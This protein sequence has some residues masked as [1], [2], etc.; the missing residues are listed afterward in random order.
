ME[1]EHCAMAG[2]NVPF[3]TGNYGITTTPQDEFNIA[4]GRMQ[5]SDINM[6]DKKGR[7]VRVI[8]RIEELKLLKLVKKAG[9]TEV[10]IIAVVSALHP[11][12][13]PQCPLGPAWV[14]RGSDSEPECRQVLYTGP[15]FQVYNAVLRRFPKEV[16]ERFA[17]GGN[18]FATTIHV[19]V[20]AV[21][22]IARVMKLPPGLELFRGLGGL[23]E[24]PESFY[25][26]A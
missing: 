3:T 19:L 9:L 11:S 23:A 12:P 13:D 2:R 26:V 15:M 10:E 22:K 1:D 16:Y 8:Q 24:L 5:C 4:V 25:Q 21:V 17:G 20:S 14:T 18:R 6:L 7:R